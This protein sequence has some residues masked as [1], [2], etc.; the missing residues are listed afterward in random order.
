MCG[1]LTI[2][3]RHT[4]TGLSQDKTC[5]TLNDFT[6][7]VHTWS[8]RAS[9]GLVFMGKAPKRNELGVTDTLLNCNTLFV[10]QRANPPNDFF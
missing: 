3:I 2:T 5:E 4:H 9:H 8:S 7:C 6:V 1:Y 10:D